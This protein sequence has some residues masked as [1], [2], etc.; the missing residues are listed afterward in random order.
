MPHA[1]RNALSETVFA[2][3]TD[4]IHDLVSTV[5]DD[6]VANAR[7]EC[8]ERFVPGGAFPFAFAAPA[9]PFEWIQNAIGIGYLVERRGTFGAVAAARARMFGIA[10]E[11][12]HF[13]RDF[14]DVSEQAAG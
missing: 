13:A 8:V 5:F 2:R 3:T 7:G 14:V 1:A 10:F 9:C 12:L 4:V 11:L 6:R